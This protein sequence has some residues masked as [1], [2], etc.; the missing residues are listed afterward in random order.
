MGRV[1]FFMKIILANNF[2]SPEGGAEKIFYKRLQLLRES[3]HEV[4]PF[5]TSKAPFFETDLSSSLFF[6]KY[7]DYEEKSN[8]IQKIKM[9]PSI[10]YSQAAYRSLS[11]LLRKINPDIIHFDNIHYHL[12]PAAIQ[13]CVDRKIPIAMSLHDVRLMCP[14]GTLMYGGNVNCDIE[15]CVGK[16]AIPCIK[17]R[18]YHGSFSKSL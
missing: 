3:G 2:F 6:P 1:N 13:A 18:C 16:S 12:T 9:L 4:I 7:R 15:A 14:A 5:A 11:V 10:F 8:P 17:G